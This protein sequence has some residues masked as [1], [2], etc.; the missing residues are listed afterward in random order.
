MGEVTL[1]EHA[2]G[3]P[4]PAACGPCRRC[5]H[6]VPVRG[7]SELVCLAYLAVCRHDEG[8]VC[9]E[10][11]QRSQRT[12]LTQLQANTIDSGQARASSGTQKA[13]P[14]MNGQGG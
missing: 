7:R 3:V 10:F 13:I 8:V 9:A 1:A 12:T 5:M 6:A 11:V 2:N 4:D 14:G